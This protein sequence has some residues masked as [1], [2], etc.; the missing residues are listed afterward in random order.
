LRAALF[1]LRAQD[2]GLRRAAENRETRERLRALGY[3]STAPPAE[4]R[5]YSAADDPKRLI[6]L[7]GIIESVL[8]RHRAGDIA[9]AL[10]LCEEVVRRR[11]G[12][13]S[14]LLCW[15][16]CA[17]GGLARAAIAAL[18]RRWRRLTTRARPAAGSYLNEAGCAESE[19]LLE[20]FAR[21]PEPARTLVARG[22][23]FGL[24]RNPE[25]A[26]SRRRGNSQQRMTQVVATV[27]L[28]A[29]D[30][31]GA[32]GPGGAA[33]LDGRLSSPS[34]LGLAAAQQGD[35]EERCRWR[36]AVA[37]IPTARRAA[38]LARAGLPRKTRRSPRLPGK[39]RR[40]RA[41]TAGGAGGRARLSRARLWMGDRRSVVQDARV[42][43]RH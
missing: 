28:L 18:S 33:R 32:Q 1:A 27:R 16:R 21:R 36:A 30:A 19:R 38:A 39:I 6:E 8:A 43:G 2:R 26:D 34:T 4:G 12:M 5:A 22:I 14:A 25:A 9:G 35:E 15:R 7:D 31:P 20:P 11:A 42:A 24:G 40:H 13:P 17:Q 29:G 23:C 37:L 3:L 41:A 10:E